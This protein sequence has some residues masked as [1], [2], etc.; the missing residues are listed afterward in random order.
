MFPDNWI[1]KRQIDFP[2]TESTWGWKKQPTVTLYPTGDL[3]ID[4]IACHEKEWSDFVSFITDEPDSYLCVVGDMFDNAIKN[5]IANP[6]DARYRPME[7]KNIMTEYLKPIRNK[8]LC[9]TRG[10]SLS[11]IR[12]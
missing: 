1:I 2:Q 9:G 4:S 12:P 6:Y 5:S 7:A 3:H 11:A 10:Q 8:I